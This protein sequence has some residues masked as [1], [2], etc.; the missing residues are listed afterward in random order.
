MPPFYAAAL[1]AALQPAPPPAPAAV[2]ASAERG[3]AFLY[4]SS[5]AWQEKRN[6]VSCHQVPFTLW[7]HH[8][9][10]RRG[11]PVDA[12]K[13]ADMDEFAF[14]FCTTNK[15]DKGELTGG[16]HLTMVDMILA[17]ESAPKAKPVLAAYEFFVPI[18][19]RRQSPEGW[20]K[21]GNQVSVKGA[22]RE[23]NEVDTMW[24]VL[25]LAELEA[26]AELP[27]KARK[28]AAA[29]REKALAWLK[30]AKA[31][32]RVDWL[33][34]RLLVGRRFG[35]SDGGKEWL[36]RLLA[37]QNKDGGWPFVRGDAS[38]PHTTGECLYALARAG[39]GG[40]HPA[41]RQACGYLLGTQQKDGSWRAGSRK[42]YESPGAKQRVYDITNH[43]ATGWATTGLIVTL[44]EE[45]A[46]R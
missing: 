9:A 1:L 33:A 22:S 5:A 21:E 31:G 34:L 44:P 37:A 11:L 45:A 24:T 10:K 15:T 6:C 17:H 28:D 38:H 26:M 14:E 20:W 4:R 40:D 19:A 42:E 41:V 12:A 25:A 30:D 8:E 35:K 43:W 39:V 32:T 13:L 18:L 23:A 27:E 2:R 3:L 7:A 46:R 36:D 16:F 29:M